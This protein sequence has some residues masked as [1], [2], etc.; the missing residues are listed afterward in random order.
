[1]NR[2]EKNKGILATRQ[3]DK[4]DINGEKEINK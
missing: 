2:R 3:V 4:G 1:V